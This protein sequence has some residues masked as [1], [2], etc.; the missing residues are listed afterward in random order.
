MVV[1]LLYGPAWA[2]AATVL[3]LVALLEVVLCALPLH[4]DLPVLTGHTRRLF[5]RNAVDTAASVTLLAIGCHWGLIGAAASRL[6]YAPVWLALYAGLMDEVVGFDRRALIR[7]YGKSLFVTLAALAPLALAL[8]RAADMGAPLFL[9][10]AVLGIAAWLAALKL[11]DHPALG[12]IAA[13][14]RQMRQF[15]RRRPA[16]A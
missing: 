10:C 2:G 6:V 7:T 12:D 5:V 13:L 3:A 14:A 1:R 4:C 9:A 16:T 15:V 11:C 8:S